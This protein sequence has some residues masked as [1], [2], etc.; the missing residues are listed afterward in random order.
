MKKYEPDEIH[1]ES[2]A[3]QSLS[4]LHKLPGIKYL[5]INPEIWNSYCILEIEINP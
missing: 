1:V 5:I 2:L 4:R 3:E